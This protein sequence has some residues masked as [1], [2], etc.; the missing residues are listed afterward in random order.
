MLLSD[1][2]NFINLHKNSKFNTS[3]NYHAWVS[4]TSKYFCMTIPKVSCTRIK[5]SLH[6]L[7]GGSLPERPGKI[8]NL[9]TRLTD[10]PLKQSISAIS[11]SDWFRFAFVRNPY[12]R[13]FSAYKS[14]IAS[15]ID[16]AYRRIRQNISDFN[17]YPVARRNNAPMICFKDFLHYV[18]KIPDKERDGHWKSQ[19]ALLSP[20]LI[21][22]DFIGRFEKFSSDFHKILKR[23]DASPSTIRQSL[24][25]INPTASI[26]L[27]YVFNRE[28]ADTVFSIYSEDFERF[29]YRYDSWMFYTE[30]SNH[31]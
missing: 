7:E 17:R 3:L 26:P 11:D 13:I 12:D 5:T 4:P 2:E 16:P 25:V 23:L 10:L 1:L 20:S 18:A 6:L 15:S 21:T 19:S 30:E 9:G 14:K 28:I 24:P 29:G 31:Q 8:H 22:Y 27:P